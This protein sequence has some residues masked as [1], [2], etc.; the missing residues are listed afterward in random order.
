M[1]ITTTITRGNRFT[2]A[3][4]A[5]AL[6]L[7]AAGIPM[8]ASAAQLSDRSVTL[9]SASRQAENVTYAV[10][11]T[12]L[13]TAA[14]FTIDFCANTPLVGQTCTA[15]DG[16]V[17][18]AAASSSVGVTSTTSPAPNRVVIDMPLTANAPVNV[19]VTGISNPDTAG[20]V[21]ARIATYAT[22]E[23][24]DSST[25]GAASAGVVDQGSV[26]FA[27]TDSVSVSGLV[28]ETLTFCVSAD[29]ISDN[30]ADVVAPTLKL[31]AETAPGSGVFAL[32]QNELNNGSLFAQINTN[33]LGGAV[34]RLKSSTID[35]GGL[36]LNG[37]DNCIAPAISNG[38]VENPRGINL[39][40]NDNSEGFGVIV[41]AA[42]DT[43]ANPD[44]IFGV[45]A[46]SIYDS[47][48]YAF[49]FITRNLTGVTST[50]GDPF[51]DTGNGPAA[52]KNV[53]MTFGATV[54]NQ[55]AAGEYSTTLDLIAVGKF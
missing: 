9:S 22:P 43:G 48:I 42:D 2:Y 26:A 1:K 4:V 54:S 41:G 53:E 10:E 8:M 37:G 17:A 29:E 20:T 51:L 32:E 34:V 46:G 31:G 25:I 13:A 27:I 7:L 12:P 14:A 35:C 45:A 24:A 15:P 18:T 19:E 47:S 52:G 39:N 55:T 40:A 23:A 16:L 50:F 38:E 44:G 49:N 30:C 5:L 11:F 6:G 21:Y 33:A 36:L 3:A 28:L